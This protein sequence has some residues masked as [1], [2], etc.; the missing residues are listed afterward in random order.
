MEITN[1]EKDKL[2]GF[3]K[4]NMEITN[5]EKDKLLGFDKGKYNE[6]DSSFKKSFERRDKVKEGEIL[7]LKLELGSFKADLVAKENENEEAG[8]VLREVEDNYQK[9]LEAKEAQIE[10][11][12]AKYFLELERRKEKEEEIQRL[13]VE[14]GS[15]K[16]I[17]VAKENRIHVLKKVKGNHQKTIEANEKEMQ[18]VQNKELE[19]RYL[20]ELE[21]KE[22]VRN[23]MYYQ[24]QLKS[25]QIYYEGVIA[26]KDF[27]L[28]AWNKWQQELE[29]PAQN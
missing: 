22:K 7:T 19:V 26:Q 24:E 4:G 13:K 17:L 18:K 8:Q 2:L 6:L 25:W 12:E 23:L 11:F 10:A 9:T 20:V 16:A 1:D 21:G 14:L 29:K 15:L 27:T 5:D 3:D 28:N